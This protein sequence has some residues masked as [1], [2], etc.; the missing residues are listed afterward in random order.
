MGRN[1]AFSGPR[2]QDIAA[3][4]LRDIARGRY[5]VGRLL[6]TE[7]ELCERFAASRHTVRDALRIVTE[8][9]LLVRRRGTGSVVI[10]TAPPNV[11]TH[12][13]GSE[14]EWMRYPT[15]TFRETVNTAEIAADRKLAAL[16]KCEPGKRWF[17]ICS[18]RRSSRIPEPLG[19]TEIYVL[20]AYA[21]VVKRSDHGTTPVH[22]QVEKMFGESIDRAQ[23]EI[24]ASH[25]PAKLARPLRVAAGTPALTVVRR[26]T[27]L[28]SGMFEV[29]V[30]IHPENRYT[31][32]MELRPQLHA[33]QL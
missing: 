14:E 12:S 27:G 20:P 25:I 7:V 3:S 18:V 26:Y 6:P 33:K 11:F 32:S 8:K 15:G 5:P 13:V 31:Y 24:F 28:K 17:R 23:L 19:W 1:P 10:A 2:Y 30:T 4:L 21:G 9:G 29:T 22:R 16:L